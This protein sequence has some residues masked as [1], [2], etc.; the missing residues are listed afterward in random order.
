MGPC[1]L[2]CT[3]SE[4]LAYLTNDALIIAHAEQQRRRITTRIHLKIILKAS[5]RAGRLQKVT[6]ILGVLGN[7]S[8]TVLRALSKTVR[9]C[10]RCRHVITIKFIT[11]SH[12]AVP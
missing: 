12:E 6:S 3:V 5:A 1:L 11:L 10:K 4:Q 7:T 2:R 8:A 9:M